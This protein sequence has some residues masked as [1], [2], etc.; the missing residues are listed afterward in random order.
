MSY[1][2]SGPLTLVAG[3]ALEAYRLVYVNSSGNA[4][5][6]TAN[7]R[8]T[9]YTL[10]PAALAAR[11]ACKELEPGSI[12]KLTAAASLSVGGNA[13]G[14]ASGKVSSASGGISYGVVADSAFADGDYAAVTISAGPELVNYYNVTQAAGLTLTTS[15][16]GCI[17]TNVGASGAAT[18]TLPTDAPTGTYFRFFVSAAQELRVLPGAGNKIVGLGALAPADAEYVTANA[19]GEH[20][21]ILANSSGDWQ[22]VGFSGTWTEQTP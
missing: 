7:I 3:E 12:A 8:G 2:Q 9:H 15:D 4:M 22:C 10:A 16:S 21:N 17:V 19:N 14:A 13:Y 20:L 18:V 1:S 5:Y 11:V 6:A